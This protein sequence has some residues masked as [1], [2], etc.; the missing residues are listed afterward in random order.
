MQQA[1]SNDPV[2]IY[3]VYGVMNVHLVFAIGAQVAQLFGIHASGSDGV[4]PG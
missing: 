1:H 4:L 3:V 2:C